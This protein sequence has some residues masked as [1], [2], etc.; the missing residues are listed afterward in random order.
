M[1]STSAFWTTFAAHKDMWSASVRAELDD[2]RARLRA[3]AGK[4]KLDEGELERLKATEADL[5]A[6]SRPWN[7]P[8]EV[9]GR[10]KTGVPR[11]QAEA[12]VRAIAATLAGRDVSG[13]RRPPPLELESLDNQDARFIIPAVTLAGIVALIVFLA[14]ANVTNVLLASA[15]G[16]R[17][18]MGTRLAIGASRA[19]IVRQLLTES[20]MLGSIA[21]A[22]GLGLAVAVLPAFAAF[23]RIPPAFD[24]S[25]D[26]TAYAFVGVLTLAA[27][28]TAGLAPARYGRPGDLVSALATDHT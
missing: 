25:P 4:A 24:G 5:S 20:V 19:R 15:A 14:C 17:R 13:A 21:G 2:T 9:F 18:E 6:P 7:P 27:G 16:R 11:P 26:L 1:G 22:L 23:V 10:L 3:M 12:E 28:V 8:V